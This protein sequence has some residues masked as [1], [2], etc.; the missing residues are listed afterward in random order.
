MSQSAKQLLLPLP[1]EFVRCL[2]MPIYT[3]VVW[4]NNSKVPYSR[5]QHIGHSGA[6]THNLW[7]SLPNRDG[8]MAGDGEKNPENEAVYILAASDKWELSHTYT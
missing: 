2:Y 7:G 4:S 6:R 5:T 3:W 8:E 1:V